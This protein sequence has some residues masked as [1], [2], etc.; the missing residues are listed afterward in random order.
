MGK[1]RSVEEEQASQ[2]KNPDYQSQIRKDV[3][4]PMSSGI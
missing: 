3:Q 1:W 4:P 2:D